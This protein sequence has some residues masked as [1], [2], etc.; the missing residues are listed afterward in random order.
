M[1]DNIAIKTFLRSASGEDF[2]RELETNAPPI[3][4][5]GIQDVTQVAICAFRAQGW[6]DCVDYIKSVQ[7]QE[8][9]VIRSNFIDQT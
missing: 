3:V 8:K 9:E 5:K 6:R 7:T 4:P 2:I 1:T